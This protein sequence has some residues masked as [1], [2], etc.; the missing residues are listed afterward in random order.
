MGAMMGK[1]N[2]LGRV[3]DKYIVL[4]KGVNGTV[5]VSVSKDI[6]TEEAFLLASKLLEELRL[7]HIRGN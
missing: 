3:R 4:S 5:V 1:V 2:E 6:T 7:R